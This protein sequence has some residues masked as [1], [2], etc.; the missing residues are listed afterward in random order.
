MSTA[1]ADF[2]EEIRAAA[3]RLKLTPKTLCQKAVRNHRLVDRLEAG[4]RVTVQTVERFR[5]FVAS[6]EVAKPIPAPPLSET[7]R[8]S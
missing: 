3:V 7:A 8:A 1:S 5:G 4:E 2:L 6:A